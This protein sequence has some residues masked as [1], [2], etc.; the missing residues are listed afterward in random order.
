[1]TIYKHHTRIIQFKCIMLIKVSQHP[2]IIQFKCIMLIKV[3][4]HPNIIQFKCIMLIKV[5][6][7][8]NIIQ[9]KCIML[10]KV[11]QNPNIIITTSYRRYETIFLIPGGKPLRL[12][13]ILYCMAGRKKIT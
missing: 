12:R 6:Q 4:Q 3:S 2:N 11:S 9:F 13:R 7:H 10:I 8:S 1:M 5:S